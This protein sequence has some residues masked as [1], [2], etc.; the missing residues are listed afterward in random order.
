MLF[1]REVIRS[2]LVEYQRMAREDIPRELLTDHFFHRHRAAVLLGQY[3][4]VHL[5]I[6]G[7]FQT[8]VNLDALSDLLGDQ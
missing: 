6:D 2:A 7:V 4:G 1:A 8:G 3:A 5:L